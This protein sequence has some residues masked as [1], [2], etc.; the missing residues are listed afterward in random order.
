MNM[1]NIHSAWT[2]GRRYALLLACCLL[3]FFAFAKKEKKQEKDIPIFYKNELSLGFGIAGINY[4]SFSS[5]LEEIIKDILLQDLRE[6]ID[7]TFVSGMNLSYKHWL[8]RR[9]AVGG[10]F[11]YKSLYR[12]RE[13][14]VNE[15]TYPAN[16]YTQNY[17]GLGIEGTVTYFRKRKWHLYGLVGA[18]G[19]VCREKGRNL[20]LPGVQQNSEWTAHYV[21]ATYQVT[22]FGVQFG[23][24]FSIKSEVGWGYKG[25]WTL[26]VAYSF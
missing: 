25:I 14:V 26:E 21:K 2:N 23:R 6:S 17:F 5:P 11:F 3:P 1:N 20:Q 16:K 8:S 9:L 19:Y 4:D 12:E 7:P 10:T 13:T 22:P 18:G 15:Q 24:K